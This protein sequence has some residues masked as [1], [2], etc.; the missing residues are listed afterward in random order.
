M[1]NVVNRIVAALLAL[2]LLL[3]GLLAAVEIVL[4]QLD[5]PAW[6]V[7]HEQWSSWLT[8]QTWDADLVRAVLAGLAALGLLLL[9]VALRRGRPGMLPLSEREQGTPS[10][11]R[12]FASRR[13][14]E[15]TL[16]SAARRVNG[17]RSAGARLARRR[18]RVQAGTAMRSPGTLKDDVGAAV[19]E[20][21]TELGL[22]TRIRPHVTISQE[23]R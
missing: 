21:L 13:G 9:V 23:K 8:G 5:R 7:P 1:M 15:R 4:A 19:G 3:G 18:A 6:L 17:V 2:V 11:V 10:G 20:R 14:V 16:A 12:V 22:G